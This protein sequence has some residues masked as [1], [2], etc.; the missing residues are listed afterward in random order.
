[1]CTDAE[2]NYLMQGALIDTKEKKNLTEERQEK[3]L[4]VDFSSLPLKDAFTIVRGNGKRKLAIFE[5]PNCGYCKRF[6]RDLQK[7]DNVTVHVFLYP[8][9]GPDSIDKARNLWCSS[10]QGNAWQDWMLRNVAAPRGCATPRRS[11]AT[12]NS[13]KHS[14]TGTPDAVLPDGTRVPGA[15]TRGRR[16]ETAGR[17]EM[18]QLPATPQACTTAS[19][20]PTS[21]RT[22]FASR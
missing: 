10:R 2:G 8:I 1:M 19:R 11:R 5:D 15:I 3:L 4:A 20:R 17:R 21:T 13:A 16:R 12:S 18:I 22:C 14:I 6:E 9:L 7:V